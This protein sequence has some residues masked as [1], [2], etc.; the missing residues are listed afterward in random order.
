MDIAVET[1]VNGR[2]AVAAWRARKPDLIF[3]DCSM[4]DM[5][6]Y[7]ATR[8]IRA[9]EA[10]DV[11]GGRTPIVALTAHIAGSNAETWRSSGMDAYMT[12]PFTLRAIAGCL[13]S[14]FAG[15][16]VAHRQEDLQPAEGSAPVIDDLVIA[17]LRKIGGSDA[18]YRRVLDLFAGRVPEALKTA[19]TLSLGGDRI[20]LA[21]AVHA[22]KSM[23]ANI[24]AR[25]AMEA[26]HDLEKA[27]RTGADLEAGPRMTAIQRETR[28]ALN[29]VEKL[30]AA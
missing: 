19:E 26:C 5:D 21:D 2:E 9:Y 15:R 4:P 23:C 18:L 11:A 8:E 3:M 30:R 25:R 20:A 10:L 7:A 24:G 13:A 14:Q 6:G 28:F 1:A 27:A 16:P 29:E 17:E 12:K 22:L